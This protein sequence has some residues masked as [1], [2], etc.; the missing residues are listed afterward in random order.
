MEAEK[1]YFD[2]P[3]PEGFLPLNL[4]FDVAQYLKFDDDFNKIA[5]FTYRANPTSAYPQV[6]YFYKF[7]ESSNL[8]ANVARK[9]LTEL[10][11]LMR[12]SLMSLSDGDRLK[13]IDLLNRLP[14]IKSSL[15][16]SDTHP[17]DEF[18]QQHKTLSMNDMVYGNTSIPMQDDQGVWYIIKVAARHVPFEHSILLNMIEKLGF[19]SKIMQLGNYTT[20]AKSEDN[21]KTWYYLSDTAEWKPEPKQKMRPANACINCNKSDTVLTCS[22]YNY[23]S[24]KCLNAFK[25]K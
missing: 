24:Y 15:M 16:G 9:L 14:I 25:E 10:E 19:Q 4:S 23:C 18:L 12:I 21:G 22:K 13:L 1:I 8:Q 11:N 5:W 7:K 17:D 2:V 3:L 20:V 6:Y